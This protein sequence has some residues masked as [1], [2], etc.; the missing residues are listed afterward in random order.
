MLCLDFEADVICKDTRLISTVHVTKK[1][2]ASITY[3]CGMPR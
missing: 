3:T 1:N 2:A